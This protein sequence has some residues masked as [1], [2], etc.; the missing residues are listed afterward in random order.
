MC[1]ILL[2]WRT[3]PDYPLILAGNRD[4]FHARPTSPAGFWEHWPQILAGRDLEHGGTWLGI[5]RSGRLAAVTNYRDGRVLR[6]GTRSRGELVSGYLTSDQAPERFLQEVHAQRS[7]YD[8]FN[9]LAGTL[10]GLFYY[11]NRGE[12]P[13]ALKPG[14][15]GLS[16]HLL[17]SPWPKVERGKAELA[18]LVGLSPEPLI[19]RLLAVLADRTIAPDHALPDTGVGLDRERILSTAFIDTPTYGTRSSTVLVVDAAGQVSF[20]ER[21][22]PTS[23]DLAHTRRYTFTLTTKRPLTD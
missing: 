21:T 5:A 20:T 23:H 7:A 3:H 9:L 1:L 15:Y 16:N 2:A 14:I 11:S 6:R 4:E 12:R 22:H 19:D 17:D 18:N 13:S 8:G 10:D